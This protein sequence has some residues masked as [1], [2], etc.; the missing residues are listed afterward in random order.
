MAPRAGGLA[1]AVPP[2]IPSAGACGWPRDIP[3]SL[4]RSVRPREIQRRGTAASATVPIDGGDEI[5]AMMLWW[6]GRRWSQHSND[7]SI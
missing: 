5:H 4:A 2:T 3:A 7:S 1:R 6:L